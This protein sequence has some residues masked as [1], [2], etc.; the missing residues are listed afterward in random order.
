VVTKGK[1]VKIF[2]A[3][4]SSGIQSEQGETPCSVNSQKTHTDNEPGEF[5]QLLK[6]YLFRVVR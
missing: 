4:V 2:L 1:V 6:M 5:K 3:S